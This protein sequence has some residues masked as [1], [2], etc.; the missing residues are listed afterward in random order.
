MYLP[1]N[2]Y[3]AV[4]AQMN[5]GASDWAGR[6][7]MRLEDQ[8]DICDDR[9]LRFTTL[10]RYF[11]SGEEY[12]DVMGPHNT[13]RHRRLEERLIDD[14]DESLR[15]QPGESVEARWNNLMDELDCQARAEKGVYLVPWEEHDADNWQNPGVTST[16]PE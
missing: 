16:G 3:Y 13:D 4:V 15:E 10:V 12:E 1:R 2:L 11:V 9:A 6:M 8:F 7:S 14:L 5:M